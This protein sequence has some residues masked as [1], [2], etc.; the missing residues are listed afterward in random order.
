MD[1]P[2]A[3]F[4]R[5]ST[6]GSR[7][8][9]S[10]LWSR[11]RRPLGGRRWRSATHR[12]TWSPRPFDEEVSAGRPAARGATQRPRVECRRIARRSLYV[13]TTSGMPGA[14]SGC[15]TSC[16]GSS[17]RSTTSASSSL[18]R[19][20]PCGRC[21]SPCRS[22]CTSRRPF[23]TAIA[24]S[25]EGHVHELALLMRSH[26][27]GVVLVNTLLTFP[28]VVA[29]ARGG[30]PERLGHSRKRETGHLLRSLR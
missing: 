1:G 20:V 4:N 2:V 15:W 18:P 23:R 16:A 21:S 10:R 6:S 3:G 12:V 28:A 29:A 8:V 9:A 22:R 25:F 19:T 14:S 17:S 7:N 27:G 24:R 11:S 5:W 13:R 30:Y 26:N